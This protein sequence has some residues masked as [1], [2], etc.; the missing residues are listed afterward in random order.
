MQRF[1]SDPRNFGKKVDIV[2]TQLDP[3]TGQPMTTRYTTDEGGN[4]QMGET[5]LDPETGLAYAPPS[6]NELV[7][8]V[9]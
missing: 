3:V 7:R 5:Q 4:I 1:F 2:G 6:V 8:L 9:F